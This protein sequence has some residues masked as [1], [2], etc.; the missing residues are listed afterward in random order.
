MLRGMNTQRTDIHRPASEDFD[1]QAYQCVGVFDTQSEWPDDRVAR[2]GAVNALIAQG[3]RSGAGNSNQCGHCGAHIRYAALM[4]RED[5]HEWIFV[6]E[7]CLGGRF[8]MTK[9]EFDTLR[10]T[11]ALNGERVARKVRLDALYAT[12]PDLVWATYSYNISEA[13]ARYAEDQYGHLSPVRNSSFADRAKLGSVFFILSDISDNV[14]RYGEISEKQAALVSKLLAQVEEAEA[15]MVAREAANAALVAKG[16][17]APSGRIVVEGTVVAQKS[18]EGDYG[19]T[20]KMLVLTD[21]GWKVWVTEPSSI[22]PTKGDRVRFT[23]TI[24]PSSD[25]VL[26][27]FGSRPSK[28]SIIAKEV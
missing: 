6:G 9:A 12:Y 10:K 22:N 4:A 28:A 24:T 1:P 17:S 20:F 25:D 8:E 3:Y 15:R 14:R 7:T 2:L 11:A 19:V 18:V 26:F 27:S 23:A 13:G 5:V 21:A 16:V